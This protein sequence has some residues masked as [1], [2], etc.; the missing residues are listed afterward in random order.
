MRV[1]T[2]EKVRIKV[3]VNQVGKVEARISAGSGIGVK[4]KKNEMMKVTKR[5]K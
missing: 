5:K 3:K 2:K 4:E 1:R